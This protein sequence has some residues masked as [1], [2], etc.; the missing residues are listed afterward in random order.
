MRRREV[1]GILAVCVAGRHVAHAQTSSRPL[2]V[3]AVSTANNRTTSFWIT[4]IKRMAELGYV[5]GQN[6]ALDFTS[7]EGQLDLYT[8][9]TAA[10]VRRGVDIIIAPGVELAL[11]SAVTATKTLPIVM[12]AV[13]YDPLA[14]GYVPSLSRPGG[15]V[16]GFTFQQLEQ[17]EKRLQLLRDA[18][19]D[20]R[21]ATVLWDQVSADQWRI[22]QQVGPKLGLRLVGIELS[23]ATQDYERLLGEAPAADRG[24][25]VV[26]MTPAVFPHRARLAEAAI[27]LGMPSVSGL[28]AYAEAGSLFSYGPSI[29]S[30]FER[31][32]D[33]VDRIARGTKA[34]ELPIEQATRFEFVIN[35][36]TARALGLAISPAFVA[37]ADEVIE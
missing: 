10:M 27:R 4:F 26:L 29:D 2:R 17:T 35:L 16:T 7:L 25:L 28:R 30:V 13:D 14:L 6:F 1:V 9:Q 15:N 24:A 22:A 23:G 11:R 19:P 33:Y 12:V 31:V 21:S 18:F 8:N 3:G 20:L 36:R 5:E 37:R 32:A 34:G